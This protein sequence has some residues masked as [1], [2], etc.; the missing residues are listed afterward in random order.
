MGSS[1]TSSDIFTTIIDG[2]GRY[3]LHPSW[4]A[5]SGELKYFL[6]ETDQAECQRLNTKYQHR[7]E[8]IKII[9]SA[10]SDSTED[11]TI[12]F[13]K[14]RAMSSS[15]TRNPISPLFKAG[16]GRE[17]EVE[18]V[19]SARIS[20]TTIDHFCNQN[21]LTINFLK[22]DTEG[23]EFKILQGAKNQLKHNILGLRCEVNFDYVFEG[24]PIFSQIHDFMLSNGFYLLNLDYEGKGDYQSN[25]IRADSKYGVLTTTDAIWMRRPKLLFDSVSSDERMACI[26]IMK[27]ASFCLLNNAPDVALSLLI[28]ARKDFNL[29]FTQF[30]DTNL[31]KFLDKKIHDLFYSLKWQPGQSLEQHQIT[32]SQI[33]EKKMKV[34]NEYMESIELN[35]D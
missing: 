15:S 34:I 8:N 27:Y 33:F 14:N 20:A 32:F 16:S 12:N 26:N 30:S 4:K 6:F 3:G 9:N 21:E 31:Y 25:L 11:V 17:L 22:L 2:G 5:F 1:S 28:N 10:L 29:H 18:I 23:S 19:S 35:P 7:S 24:E 13:F